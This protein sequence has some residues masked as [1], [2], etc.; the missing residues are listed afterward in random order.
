VIALVQS[1]LGGNVSATGTSPFTV[2]TATASLPQATGAGNLLVIVVGGTSHAHTVG[3]FEG[4]NTAI[5]VP[6]IASWIT[7]AG[8]LWRESTITTGGNTNIY[9][10]A[11]APSVPM[12]TTVSVT[13]SMAGSGV[14]YDV[15]GEFTFYEFSGVATSSPVDASRSPG[16][17]TGVPTAGN[18]VTSFTDLVISGYGGNS[19]NATAGAT[20]TL[21]IPMSVAQFC[22]IQYILNQPAGTIN[23]SFGSGS[24]TNFGGFATSFKPAP[25]PVAHGFIFGDL[26][27]F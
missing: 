12:G 25:P 19:S 8:N 13:F 9:Y 21:G 10:A 17:S 6:G 3:H 26:F 11:N 4:P 2:G 5:S 18:L 15:V 7:P 14:T 23:T 24:Q 1:F 16:S 27:G 20:Y 22:E